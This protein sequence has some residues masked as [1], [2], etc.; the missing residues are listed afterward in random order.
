MYSVLC[1]LCKGERHGDGTEAEV[2][3]GQVGD[4]H[5]P[6]EVLSA[7]NRQV[8]SFVWSLMQ[9]CYT[10]SPLTA[11]DNMIKMM[12]KKE[13]EEKMHTANTRP[14]RTC[15]IQ[16]YRFSTMSL[17]QYHWWCQYH[18]SM[19]MPWFHV[20][21]MSPYLYHESMS[22]P[23]VLANNKS[24]CPYHE[25]RNLNYRFFFFLYNI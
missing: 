22:T 5:V 12:K 2:W 20:S 1:D 10:F 18:E 24:H 16:E 6:G 17:S 4:E 9:L 14:S 3:H 21:T 8:L 23:W 15:V 13:K 25:S 19:S 7:A 11:K